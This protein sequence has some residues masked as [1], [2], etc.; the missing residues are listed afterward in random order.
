MINKH[1][2]LQQ[3]LLLFLL[4][5]WQTNIKLRQWFLFSLGGCEALRS[6]SQDWLRKW[7]TNNSNNRPQPTPA[8]KQYR[9]ALT[10]SNEIRGSRKLRDSS[11]LCGLYIRAAGW[12]ITDNQCLGVDGVNRSITVSASS[13]HLTDADLFPRLNRYSSFVWELS[14]ERAAGAL[15]P[16]IR[17][18]MGD[19]K[20][21][22][23]FL[24][25]I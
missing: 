10:R 8:L 1:R 21:S 11:S 18:R 25:Q 22:W 2:S 3:A 9:F 19:T 4:Y 17:S 15:G 20:F 23:E 13:Y 6:F 16:V 12:L 24:F 7:W 5:F 14:R